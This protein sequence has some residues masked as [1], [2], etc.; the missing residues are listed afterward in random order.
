MTSAFDII[1]KH[2]KP[3]RTPTAWLTLFTTLFLSVNAL[4]FYTFGVLKAWET[5]TLGLVL[6]GLFVNFLITGMSWSTQSAE[7]GHN[8]RNDQ[9]FAT[10]LLLATTGFI[11]HM[12]AQLSSWLTVEPHNF[13]LYMFLNILALESQ[14]PNKLIQAYRRQKHEAR[15]MEPE[16]IAKAIKDIARNSL[17][18]GEKGF[19]IIKV[20]RPEGWFQNPKWEA[21][22]YHGD[23]STNLIWAESL[24]TFPI[25]AWTHPDGYVYEA[26]LDPL[27]KTGH[28]HLKDLA[29]IQNLEK[30]LA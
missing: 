10:A 7:N 28:Q 4:S 30:A 25:E 20:K 12:A 23:T 15:L 29:Q 16:Q 3:G 13:F 24:S 26:H 2:S 14:V 19:L 27:Q 18:L 21:T 1:K 5:F 11:F 17:P 6:C 22:L 8:T 9:A